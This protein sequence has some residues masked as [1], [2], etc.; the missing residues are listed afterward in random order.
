[1][2][3]PVL[4][5]LRLSHF[6]EKA[7]WALDYKAVAHVRS[8]A[9]PGLHAATAMRLNRQQT[10][11]ILDIDGRRIGE[12][13]EIIEALEE[14][15]P[16]PTLHPEDPEHLRRAT[17]LE[18][19]LDEG[20]GPDVRRIF[21][22]YM[23]SE[24]PDAL[25]DVWTIP[26][27]NAARAAYNAGFGFT[28]FAA[29]QRMRLNPDAVERSKA[30]VKA[31]L[32]GIEAELGD[33]DYLAGNSFSLADLTVASLLFPIVRPPQF[34]YTYPPVPAGLEGYREEL[35]SRPV[36]AWVEEMWRRHRG[37][38]AAV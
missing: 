5:Q 28:K 36:F 9:L 34:Q 31:A 30:R 32:D 6:N 33:G 25:R 13:A 2:T 3:L 12:S 35:G 20:L 4:W 24:A 27:G 10:M 17:E 19:S 23:L 21:V 37:T 15:A 29:G 1:M 18:A 38:S 26:A 16:E 14:R 7:R 11:P 8:D 22:F